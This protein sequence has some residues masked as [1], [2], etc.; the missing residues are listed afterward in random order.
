MQ[1]GLTEAEKDE[2]Y[3]EATGSGSWMSQEPGDT[4]E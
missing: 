4:P 1:A 3:G 2:M